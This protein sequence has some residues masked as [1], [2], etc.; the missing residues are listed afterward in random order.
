MSKNC[1]ESC[2]SLPHEKDSG[3]LEKL[4]LIKNIVGALILI[5][6][7]V[8]LHEFTKNIM[9]I[10]AYIILGCDVILN[11]VKNIFKGS[12]FDENFLMTLATIAAIA[13]GQY[14]EA[15]AVMALYQVGEFFSKI[16]VKRSKKSIAALMELK[17]DYANLLKDGKIITVDPNEVQI[18][19]IIVVKAGEKIPLDGVVINGSSSLDCKALTGETN[20]YD[21]TV[22]DLVYSGSINY[23]GALTIKVLKKYSDSTAAKIIELMENVSKDGSKQ[24]KFI[25]K[26]AKIYTPAVVLGAVLLACI[27]PLFLGINISSVWL[28]WLNRALI[29]LIISCPCA[30]VISVPL[31]YFCGIGLASRF[32]ILVKSGNSLDALSKI[33]IVA[34]DKTGTITKGNIKIKNIVPKEMSENELLMLSAYAES[35]SNHPIAKSITK[36]FGEK[37]DSSKILH[38]QEIAGYGVICKIEGKKVLCGNSKLMNKNNI[39]YEHN[40]NNIN[41]YIA[42][43]G[44]YSGHIEL[45]DEIKENITGALNS[46]K[47][48][49]VK[50]TMLISGDS[51]KVTQKIANDL[52]FD[53]FYAG[54]LPSQKL[55]KIEEIEKINKN[56]VYV[57]DG[58]NDAPC[59]KKVKAGIAMGGLGSDAAKQSADIVIM[60]DDIEKVPAAIK[61]SKKTKRIAVQ[62]IAFSLSVKLIVLVLGA[63]GIASILSAIFADV[64][65][66]LI[67]V[68]NAL[69]LLITLSHCHGDGGVDNILSTPPSP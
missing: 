37:I 20:F 42:I 35:V 64:G 8:I 53:E 52:N 26:F 59:L 28:E 10:T 22:D 27:P 50:K 57:G 67:C 23:N 3:I 48:L 56:I 41:V 16:A 45:Y 24:E 36:A 31:S 11:A 60:N 43:D 12:I 19:D 2:G 7:L 38:A 1:C 65:V 29:F 66:T 49:G 55:E 68:L 15:C 30:L 14:L 54:L 32:G 9:F 6:A 17:S 25:T 4:L 13:T 21:V 69:R 51:L 63:F 39:A 61:I 62:N 44:V 46:L 47:M 58:I 40:E 18:S 33:D 34:F 5:A